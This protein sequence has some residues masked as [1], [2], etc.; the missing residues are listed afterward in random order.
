MVRCRIHHGSFVV[1]AAV[2]GPK[3]DAWRRAVLEMAILMVAIHAA[4]LV[5]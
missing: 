5:G 4:W 1:L 3:M 2:S